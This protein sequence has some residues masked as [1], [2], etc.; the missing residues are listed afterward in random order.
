MRKL[1]ILTLACSC[2][3]G[4][5]A[6]EKLSVGHPD[7]DPSFIKPYTAKFNLFKFEK[8]GKKG[9]PNGYW[10]DTVEFL[11]NGENK[12]LHRIVTRTNAKGDIDLWRSHLN[13]AKT[14]APITTDNRSGD[15]LLQVAH[16]DFNGT[17]IKAGIIPAPQ[18]P[19]MVVDF[20]TEEKVFDLSIWASILMSVPFEEGYEAEIPVLG[21]GGVMKYEYI[22]VESEEEI[23]LSNG[24]KVNTWRVSTRDRPWTAWLS[25]DFSP[26]IVKTLQNFKDGTRWVSYLELSE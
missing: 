18:K 17:K 21:A 16:L 2:L 10:T 7:I 8:D 24:K 5:N 23:T 26:Y 6:A 11:G 4:L 22:T 9:I 13:H 1:L 19:M 15:N 14:L 25:K 12:Q 3:T 20:V